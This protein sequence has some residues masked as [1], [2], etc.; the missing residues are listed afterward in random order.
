M[1]AFKVNPY[2]KKKEAARKP[3]LDV[4]SLGTGEAVRM[5]Y[6]HEAVKELHEFTATVCGGSTMALKFVATHGPKD[7]GREEFFW[8]PK[9]WR[10]L[11]VP[12]RAG[13]WYLPADKAREIGIPKV[14]TFNSN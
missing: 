4:S 11:P 12:R 5:G 10:L 13:V 14:L 9:S 1:K 8:L 3:G 6:Y 7:A 2:P